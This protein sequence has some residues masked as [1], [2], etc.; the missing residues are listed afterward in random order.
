MVKRQDP[1]PRTIGRVATVIAVIVALCL[2]AG[3]FGLSY[4]YQVGAM[5]AEARYSAAQTTQYIVLNPEMWRFQVLRLNEM[6]GKDLTETTLP[7][8]R[9]IVDASSQAVAAS[10]E[11]L[12]P[13]VLA[14]R[15]PLF[16]AGKTVG[17]FEVSRS[18]RPLLLETGLVALLGMAL[19]AAV[20]G[21]LKIL[22]LRALNRALDSLRQSEQLF[23][24]AF[25]ASPDPVMICRVRDGRILN[26]ND[27]FV[28]LTGYAPSE[29][30]GRTPSEVALWANEENMA[31]A[32]EQLRSDRAV[33][34]LDMTL[35]TKSGE[36][37]DMLV[38]SEMAEINDEDCVLTVAR[39]VTEQKRAEQ[40][41]AYLANYDHL[42]GLPNRALFHDRL[43]GA[44]QRAQ[45]AEHLVGLLYLDLDRFK[46]VNDSLGHPIGDQL[47]KQVAERLQR[48]VRLSDTVALPSARDEG[49]S[50]TVARLG[51][52][53]FTI[54]LEDIK[55]IDEIT[56][57]AQRIV[58]DLAEPF[59]LDGHQIFVGASIGIA[60]YPFDDVDL[61]NLIRNADAAMYRAKALGRNN[62]QFY[63]DDLNAN[64]EQRLLLETELH[65]ALDRDQFELVYQPKLNLR[66]DLITGVE[67]LLRWNSP[68]NGLVS[69]AD[70]IPSL[71]ETGLIV[72]VGAWVLRTACEQAAAW[73]RAGLDLTMAVNLSARQF[74]DA[75]L[76][77]VIQSTLVDTGLPANQLELEVTESLLMEDSAGSQATLTRIKQMGIHISVD[78]FGT[79]Y[80]SLAYLKRFP[81]DTLKIDRAFVKDIGVDAD[82]TAIVR[83]V[84]AL[85]HS[86]RLT[87][88]AEGVETIEQ[89]RFLRETQCEQAQG[90]F[91]SRPMDAAAFVAW[92]EARYAG[93]TDGMTPFRAG[94]Q[95]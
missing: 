13:P 41:M 76:T 53:E 6:L 11:K 61:D 56:R 27:S 70:F 44:M 9:R 62:F 23:S 8:Q 55:H 28:R 52:D 67:A 93:Q 92:M 24:K 75:G 49:V 87:V 71:E 39:D 48:Y 12:A 5:R 85:A 35:V 83:A 54:V 86:L 88:V 21:V 89:L 73:T 50:T 15:A 40:R 36:H 7:E 46:Q 74:R 51:G 60:V 1:F 95:A 91:I 45:R 32:K 77:G 58:L 17:Y 64:A 30:L 94:S 84:L 90:Y 72:P 4:Q 80:S 26:V 82:G 18:L 57:I 66:T 2:P 37:R 16:D 29:V 78:D 19:A 65:Q 22:P 34:N 38:S 47:L 33:H 59:D 79:G 81:L 31:R 25:H 10:G 20:F 43:A 42:T 3:F 69:P 14:I 68:R 63:T